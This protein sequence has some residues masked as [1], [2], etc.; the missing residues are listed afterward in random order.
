VEEV[1]LSGTA[2]SAVERIELKNALS[3]AP[4]PEQRICLTNK[5]LSLSEPR[6]RELARHL[7]AVPESSKF[8]QLQSKLEDFSLQALTDVTLKQRVSIKEL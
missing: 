8:G 2:F 1:M 5:I 6:Q 3:T 4:T 7:A